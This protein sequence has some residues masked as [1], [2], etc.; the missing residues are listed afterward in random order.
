MHAALINTHA[1]L[2]FRV[3]SGWAVLIVLAGPLESPAIVARRRIE[4][5]DPNVA[6][7]KQPYH[8]AEGMSPQEAER[9]VTACAARSSQLATAAVQ[10]ALADV[11]HHGYQVTA[12]GVLTGSGQAVPELEKILVSHPLLHT[13]EGELFRSAIIAACKRCGMS[14]LVVKEK[15]LLLRHSRQLAIPDTAIQHHLMRM[16]KMVGPPWRQDE[17]FATRVAWMALAAEIVDHKQ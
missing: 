2:G 14:V 16:G 6:G 8:A 15:E 5:A 11:K 3:H 13:A 10:S 9:H 17:K 1:A 4:I 7:S 12:A